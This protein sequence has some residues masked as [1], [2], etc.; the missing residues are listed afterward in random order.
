MDA[1]FWQGKRVLVT[2]HT[3]FKG[4]WISLWLLRLGAKVHGYALPSDAGSLFEA[5]QLEERLD[6]HEIG[7]VRDL[8][9]VRA[10]FER[11]APELV[12]HMAAQSLVRPSY[13]D[14]VTTMATNVMGTVHVLEAA[15]HTPSV[16][17]VLVVTSDKCYQNREWVWGYRE[18]EALGGHDPY[19]SSKACAELVTASYR[20]SY[21][22]PD[23]L[24][25]HGVAVASARV[26]NV[27]GGGDR[28]P[29][30]LIPDLI[31]ALR[32][33][34]TVTLRNPSATRPWQHV[35]EPLSGYLMLLERLHRHDASFCDA[36]NLGPRSDDVMTVSW[37]A[38]RM[39]E[40]WGSRHPAW[41][42]DPDHGAAPHEAHA[43]MLDWSKARAE[44][45]WAPRWDLHEALRRTVAWWQACGDAPEGTDDACMDDIAAYTAAATPRFDVA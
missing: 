37:I 28:S 21:F 42:L 14:P 22:P 23:E 41:R 36:W 17:G 11:D 20:S 5:L 33:E 25:R 44:L 16:R 45:G 13:A 18:H 38:E 40:L 30:R 2:G 32:Q 10:A 35:L 27:I 31:T 4:S 3:G 34:Q 12:I 7:D 39:A 8:A 24:A 26:G 9:R 6:G 19:S 29:D 15:R 1:S 43:L